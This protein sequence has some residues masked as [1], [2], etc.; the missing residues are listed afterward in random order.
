MEAENK[1]APM[2]AMRIM[3]FPPVTGELAP[4]SL[5]ADMKPKNNVEKL[6]MKALFR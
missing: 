1:T 6:N 2:H 5:E 3:A 4:V